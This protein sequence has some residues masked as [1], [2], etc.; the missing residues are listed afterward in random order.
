MVVAP[1]KDTIYPEHLPDAYKQIGPVARMD[2]VMQYLGTK[3]DLNILDLRPALFEAK[4]QT[5]VF[6]STD[7]HWNAYGAFPAYQAIIE[8]LAKDVS[9]LKPMNASD[10][11]PQG[12]AFLGGDLSYMVGL[13]E[14]ITENKTL[15]LPKIPLTARGVSTG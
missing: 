15:M 13:E 3:T 5:Q 11:Y 9:G 4:K 12:Y 8:R 14:L 10:F 2:Q 6:Y 7:S 1:N